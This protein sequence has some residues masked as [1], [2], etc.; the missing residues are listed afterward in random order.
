M[1]QPSTLPVPATPPRLPWRE[2][3]ERVV[4][5]MREMSEQ[6]DPQAMVSAYTAR[7]REIM[8]AYRLI[9]LSRR[10]LTPP[11]YR[12]TRSTMW[13]TPINPWLERE[14]LPL[15]EGGLLGELIY[16]NEPRIIDDLH[17]TPDDP[18][19]EHFDGYRSLAAIPQFDRGEA[20]NMVVLLRPQPFAFDREEFPELV[21]QSNLF[22]RATH[23]LVLTAELRKTYDLV[24]EELRVVANIQRSLLPRKLPKVATLDLGVHYQTSRQAGGDYY[25]FFCLPDGRFGIL[26]ADVSGHGTPAAVVMA[27]THSIAHAFPGAP[28]PPSE[29]LTFLNRKLSDR[30]GTGAAP[31]IPGTLNFVTAFYGIYDAAERTLT[32]SSAGHN[33]PR[34]RRANRTVTALDRERHLPLGIDASEPY[35]DHTERLAPG[36][37]LVF[38]TDGITEARDPMKQLF[39]TERLDEVIRQ[40]DGNAGDMVEAIIDAVK[41]FSGGRPADDD[42]TLLVAK[43]V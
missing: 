35:T 23:N 29:M 5:M 40:H 7:L 37:K 26:I 20:L 16:G 1:D 4:E 22:G 36:D 24:E 14:K 25:D 12:I 13:A 15:L 6:T 34:L 42:R 8:P 32:F 28:T 27:V 43:V 3:L 31:G 19:A 39:G 33:P 18:A 9:S 21:W 10:N 11:Q 17:V 38:Y 2:R 30:N 41:K